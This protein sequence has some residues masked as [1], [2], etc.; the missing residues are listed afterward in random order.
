MSEIIDDEAESHICKICKK[1]FNILSNLRRHVKRVHE[2]RESEKKIKCCICD[3]RCRDNYQLKVH[4]RT[5]TRE[6]PFKCSH[7][8]FR[9]S[10]KEDCTRHMKKCSGPKY[11]CSK[12]DKMFKSKHSINDHL[13]WDSVCGNLGDQNVKQNLV[14]IV[15]NKEMSVLGVN[16]NELIDDNSFDRRK[17]KTRCGVCYNCCLELDCGECKYCRS[18]QQSATLKQ[19][20]VK[21]GCLNPVE[22]YNLKPGVDPNTFSLDSEDAIS[23]E[24]M[25]DNLDNFDTLDGDVADEQESN[26]N[27]SSCITMN[28]DVLHK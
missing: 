18:N 10:K 5:H 6:K 8:E 1:K 4:H 3:Y 2:T 9:S 16:C 23:I 7:C 14:K 11:Q 22:L 28:A 24:F 27:P 21:R 12:C 26:I 25:N 13:N 17:R 15:I 20:C 19:V